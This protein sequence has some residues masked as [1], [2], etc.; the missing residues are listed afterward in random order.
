[1]KKR[2]LKPPQENGEILFLPE[3]KTVVSSLL[4]AHTF[5]A[6][7]QP[8]F[9]NP[10]VSTKYLFL[11]MV[12]LK[13]KY[14]FLDTD[15]AGLVVNIPYSGGG[16]YTKELIRS[17]SVLYDYPAPKESFFLEFFS[18]LER[19][20][21]KISPLLPALLENIRTFKEIILSKK[22]KFLKE[23]LVESFLAFYG[24]EAEYG[25]VSEIVTSP[26]FREFFQ[27][28][29]AKS[30]TFQEV[31]NHS[32]DEYR[33]EFKFRYKHFP[34]PALEKDELPF[35]I[36]RQRKRTRCFKKDINLSEFGKRMIIP[37]ASTLALFLRLY[38]CDIFIHGVGGANYEWVQDRVIERFFKKIPPLYLVISGTFLLSGFQSREFPYFFFPPELIRRRVREFMEEKRLPGWVKDKR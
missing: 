16:V 11:D 36:V 7:H 1:M 31:F 9:F 33:N 21:K 22:R 23:L 6:S 34:F 29:Y 12:P 10:G 19:E 13:K 3:P 20:I 18:F 14:L 25:F 15:R 26:E 28:I 2:L 5:C 37:R 30:N 27:M 17:E 35:W 4:S 8:Y 24:I 38:A 32:L